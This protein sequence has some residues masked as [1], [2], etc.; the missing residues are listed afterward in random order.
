MDNGATLGVGTTI[1]GFSSTTLT[2]K[3]GSNIEIKLRDAG[4]LATRAGLAG[5]GYDTFAFGDIVLSSDVTT[6]NKIM[7]VLKSLDL[8]GV[9]GDAFN[10][11]KPGE[12]L[13]FAFGTYSS[14]TTTYANNVSDLFAFDTTDFRYTGGASSNAGL[15]SIEFNAGAITLS[16][17]AA[18]P[19]PSTYGFGLGALALAAAA[20]R[21]RK[22]QEKK[23]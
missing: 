22:R 1:G 6:S 19:E 21:R 10:V 17:F 18:V 23:A 9:L 11:A 13:D 5:T 8:A 20:I 2:L 16:T 12:R 3:G 15:W 4:T 14:I 7:I